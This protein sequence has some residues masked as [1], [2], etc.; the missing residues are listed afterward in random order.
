MFP[1]QAVYEGERNRDAIDSDNISALKKA[2]SDDLG[3]AFV[4]VSI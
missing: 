3:G 2:L 1:C 4:F